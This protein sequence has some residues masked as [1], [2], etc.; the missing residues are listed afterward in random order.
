M[1]SGPSLSWPK[2]VWILTLLIKIKI[3][4]CV[5][6]KKDVKMLFMSLEIGLYRRKNTWRW[7]KVETENNT[8]TCTT[9]Q[10]LHT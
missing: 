4:E 1:T 8:F 6:L 2:F 7:N 10:K 3:K 9:G 5:N